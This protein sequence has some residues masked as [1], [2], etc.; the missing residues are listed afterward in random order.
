[1]L[2]LGCE[3]SGLRDTS[4]IFKRDGL[5]LILKVSFPKV[6]LLSELTSSGS[7]WASFLEWNLLR[8]RYLELVFFNRT[9]LVAP[10]LRLSSVLLALYRLQFRSKTPFGVKSSS[11][12]CS[13]YWLSFELPV[14]FLVRIALFA[15]FYSIWIWITSSFLRFW[16]T[17]QLLAGILDR[18]CFLGTGKIILR[19]NSLFDISWLARS[20]DSEWLTI[21]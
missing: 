1:M 19:L 18:K 12:C 13:N 8:S 5:L 20:V 7:R 15:L 3:G 4:G 17:R 6:L 14:V 2:R 9:E 21:L 11:L 16:S 10:Y